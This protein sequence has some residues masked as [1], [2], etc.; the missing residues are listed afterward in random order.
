VRVEGL[1]ERMV[2]VQ[3]AKKTKK[4]ILIGHKVPRRRWRGELGRQLQRREGE[5]GRRL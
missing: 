1:K 4:M 5:E 2:R 3:M